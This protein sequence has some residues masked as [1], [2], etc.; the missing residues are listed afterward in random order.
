MADEKSEEFRRFVLANREIIENILNEGKPDCSE[1]RKQVRDDVDEC[2]DETKAR[3]IEFNNAV[4][5]VI[6]DDDVQKHFIAGCLEFVHFFESVLEAMPLSPETREA[7]EK[8]HVARDNALRNVVIAG[9][10]DKMD[11]L[12]FEDVKRSSNS[13]K[14]RIENISIREIKD[15]VKRNL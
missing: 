5:Q 1:M 12:T 10:K 2:I 13:V 6:G 7:V 4:L 3:V 9:A 8:F 14:D 15:T 11:N